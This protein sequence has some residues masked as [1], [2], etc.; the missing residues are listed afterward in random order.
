MS[1]I[2]E[3]IKYLRKLNGLTQEQ[4]SRRIGIKR[5]LLGAYEE[6]RANPN[7]NNLIVIAK[8]FNVSVENL[9]KQ[10]LRKLRE[11]P[12]LRMSFD[13][14]EQSTSVRSVPQQTPSRS[15]FDDD[16][17]FGEPIKPSSP[18]LS[19]V[20]KP[21]ASVLEKYYKAPQAVAPP[22]GPHIAAERPPFQP[23]QPKP[24]SSGQYDEQRA[25]PTPPVI[26]EPVSPTQPVNRVDKHQASP[27]INAKT[28]D[29]PLVFNNTYNQAPVSASPVTPDEHGIQAIPLVMQYQ[30]GEYM[31][32]YQ[33]ADYLNRLPALRLPTL[34][35]GNYRAFEADADFPMPGALLVGQFIRNWFDI[36]DGR[37]YILILNHQGVLC[38]RIFN[39]VK[40]KGTLLLTADKATIPSREVPLKDVLEVWE[41]KA[42]FSQ[43][44]PE[45]P[46]NLDR[47]RQLVDELRFE[48]DRIK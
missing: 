2:S 29:P 18:D 21:L 8:S 12:S 20:P 3:N 41:I 43:Q 23:E 7:P 25:V 38:R 30:F 16:D 15:V 32:R 46:P 31:Q 36:I 5:S 11:T 26:R 42:F 27:G 44:L 14:S 24:G 28:T 47:L 39:Q 37:L 6:G 22:A 4:F 17:P 19:D 35:M 33:Q 48:V 34:P 40:I 45:L 10:D 9:Q 1:L 13:R